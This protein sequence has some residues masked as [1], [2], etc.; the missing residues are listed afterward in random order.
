[1]E[2][3]VPIPGP[4]GLPFVGNI[5]DIDTKDFVQSLIKLS[6]QYGERNSIHKIRN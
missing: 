1:M 3:T 5:A 2:S 4:R 6:S